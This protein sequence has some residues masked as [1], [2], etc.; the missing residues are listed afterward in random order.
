MINQ[1]KEGLAQTKLPK[2]S[3]PGLAHFFTTVGL[4]RPVHVTSRCLGV[5]ID[6]KFHI[7]FIGRSPILGFLRLLRRRGAGRHH[8]VRDHPHPEQPRSSAASPGSWLR[9]T[10]ARGRSSSAIFFVIATYLRW[11]RVDDRAQRGLPHSHAASPGVHG[12]A[13]GNFRQTTSRDETIAAGAPGRSGVGVPLIV[14]H[15]QHPHNRS[16]R[17]TS[18]SSGC[19]NALRPADGGQ[20]RIGSTLTIPLEDAVIWSRWIEDFT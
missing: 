6:P 15:L 4:L 5:L 7:P 16:A 14:Q 19:S 12:N 10:A 3:I 13:A 20:G 11:R 8:R 18:P 9:T 2:R 17:S 1:N